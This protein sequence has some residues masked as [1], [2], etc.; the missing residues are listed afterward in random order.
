[1]SDCLVCQV[2]AASFLRV[3]RAFALRRTRSLW[4][5]ATGTTFSNDLGHHE[6][7]GAHVGATGPHGSPAGRLAAVARQWREAGQLRHGFVGQG[8]DLGQFSH[9]GRDGA[10]GNALDGSELTIQFRP[11]GIVV[12]R[13]GD[14]VFERP[15]LADDGGQDRLEGGE[16]VGFG[17][18]TALVGL[19]DLGL[20]E[21]AQADHERREAR[22]GRGGGLHRSDPLGLRVPGDHAAIDAIG[23]L[24]AAHG[25]GELANRSRIDDRDRLA[26]APKLGEGQ[27]L[28]SAR[29]LHDDEVD[30]VLFAKLRQRQTAFE[31]S[32]ELSPGAVLPD[33]GVERFGANI[34]STNLVRHG[35]LPCPCDWRSSDC[36][37]V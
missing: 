23:L 17:H 13:L 5:R 32:G 12:D 15:D 22:L 37:V 9:Q 30:V 10:I 8:V 24:E 36:P 3:S 6:E 19:H 31:A 11:E 27:P 29:R 18:E 33:A 34:H 26:G 28:V 2:A 4:A 16:S 21:L 25:F 20:G 1:M 35:H 14:L 7:D